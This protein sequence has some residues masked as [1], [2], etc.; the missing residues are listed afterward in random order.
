MCEKIDPK[1]IAI[2][3]NIDVIGI[4]QIVKMFDNDEELGRNI[5]MFV[6]QCEEKIQ[7]TCKCKSPLFTRTV[8]ESFNPLCG[9]CGLPI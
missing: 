9:D 4:I 3:K 7:Q 2:S 1:T 8:D 5:R 6:S